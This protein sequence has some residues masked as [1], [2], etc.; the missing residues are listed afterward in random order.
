M[1]TFHPQATRERLS[2]ES[3]IPTLRRLFA[4]GCEVPAH[5]VLALDT[6]DGQGVTSP[7]M[8]ALTFLAWLVLGMNE[9]AAGGSA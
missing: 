6:P 9:S 5:Q 7:I 8:Q 1:R 3:V 4:S 2:F